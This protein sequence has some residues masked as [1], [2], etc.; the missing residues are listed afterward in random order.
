[1]P[2]PPNN[3]DTSY[4]FDTFLQWRAAVRY[5]ADDPFI[6]KVTRR[7]SGERFREVDAAARTLDETVSIRWRDLSDAA[8]R[9]EKRP[10]MLHYDGHGNR[11][12]RI[13]R[14]LEVVELEREVFGQGLFSESTS[15][16]ERLVKSYLIYQ[17]GEA[18]IACPLVCT[19]GLAA[20]LDRFAD[21]PPTQMMLRHVCEGIDG[22][23][24]V[25]A[26]YVSE[27]Q[28]GSDIPA[29]VVEAVEEGGVWRLFGQKFFCS[30]THADYAVVT[31]KPRGSNDVA[32]FVMPSWLPGK[33]AAE[34]RNGYTID[35][36]KWKMGT[37]ELP[38]AELTFHG[39]VAYP[40][41]PLDRGVANVVGVVLTLSRLTVGL[42]SAANMTR[43]AREAIAYANFRE[44]FGRPIA[45]FPMVAG[46]LMLMD[47]FAKCATA[48]AFK[49]YDLY[50]KV[51]LD[52]RHGSRGPEARRRAF[53]VRE[54]IMLQKIATTWDST[55]MVRM[56]MS[57][58]G[59][60]GVMEDFSSLPRLY[61][62]SAVNEL[63]E[64][65]R[66]TLLA[67]L[68]RDLHRAAAWYPPADFIR[69]ILAGAPQH[70]IDAEAEEAEDLVTH[71]SLLEM[72]PI[73]LDTC[74]R[75]DRFCQELFHVF[76]DVAVS[77]VEG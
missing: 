54:L 47:Q 69:N 4:S 43:A 55:D 73:T 12:D 62:D 51:E 22:G 38:T 45:Q 70:L 24:A 13:V 31:A 61:R 77:E 34:E 27:I 3:T 39:A 19:E 68:H 37:S 29:N 60:H 6:Q 53:D 58:F 52:R 1:M 56:A 71:P 11:I 25:G 32:L 67:Q 44:A 72:D 16:M 48:G 18:C 8:S 2:G 23:F 42:S 30:A 66:N 75:W 17:N 26:Q 49:V 40:L 28:G 57:I 65:P 15:D 14:P 36:L 10:F 7:F 76:Q 41:G 59:G 21:S 46:Q 74:R 20:V 64:G 50:F 63:W 33:K 9:P 35:R 5:Y